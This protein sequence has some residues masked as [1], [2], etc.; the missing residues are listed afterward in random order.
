MLESGLFFAGANRYWCNDKLQLSPYADDGILR[1]AEIATLNLA[2]CSLVVLSACETGLG[3]SNSS[4]GV[5]GLQRAFKLAGAKQILMSLWAVDDRATDMLMT[6][7]Y[8][9]LLRGEDADEAL[10]KSK[11]HLRKMYPSPEDWGAFVLLH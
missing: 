8:Q 11:A 6:G 7:F 3:Y 10:Q 4:E 2:D 5:Y 9:G 1:S